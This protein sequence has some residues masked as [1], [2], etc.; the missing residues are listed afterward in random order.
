[1][2]QGLGAISQPAPP[3]RPKKPAAPPLPRLALQGRSK[4]GGPEQ[5]S[6]CLPFVSC[7][8][9]LPPSL[10]YT[11]ASCKSFLGR[12]PDP[13]LAGTALPPPHTH[14]FWEGLKGQ[15]AA[16]VLAT[17]VTCLSFPCSSQAVKQKLP[18]GRARR[19]CELSHAVPRSSPW[20]QPLSAPSS[21]QWLS[22]PPRGVP[23]RGPSRGSG[24]R[25]AGP[26]ARVG[27]A[28]SWGAAGRSRDPA[29]VGRRA[30]PRRA[31]EA[32]EEP[33]PGTVLAAAA[34]AGPTADG[35]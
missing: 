9:Q 4:D 30:H 21:R 12:R 31:G 24:A 25:S 33:P 15:R 27:G 7:P 11:P 19:W 32:G 22:S 1:M 10:T 35:S 2:A 3:S 28:A 8:R 5:A 14:A 34:E 13:S 18:T 26:G 29:Q 23:L 16:A 17:R 20:P 6:L